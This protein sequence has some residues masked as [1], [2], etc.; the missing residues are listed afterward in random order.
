MED[1]NE[2]PL[3]NQNKNMKHINKH[4]T[5]YAITSSQKRP[6]SFSPKKKLQW[7]R[8]LSSMPKQGGRGCPKRSKMLPRGRFLAV[9]LWVL[10]GKVTKE[11]LRKPSWAVLAC[12]D[13]QCIRTIYI[14]KSWG[15]INH[16]YCVIRNMCLKHFT[17]ARHKTLKKAHHLF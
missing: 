10:P 14:M 13:K 5:N 4:P 11:A 3:N 8:S 7:F 16:V 15:N 2:T 9:K 12:I 1:M 17:L 6:G